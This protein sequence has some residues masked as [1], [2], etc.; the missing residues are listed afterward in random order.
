MLNRAFFSLQANWIPTLVALGN[1]FV[2]VVLD[3]AVRR[4]SASGASRWRRRS[5]TSRAPRRCS[6]CCR[7]RVGRIDF[8]EVA[9]SSWRIVVAAAVAGGAAFG[10]WKALDVAFGDSVVGQ[11][12]AFGSDHRLGRGLRRACLVLHVRELH[13]LLS[14]R[15]RIRAAERR[16]DQQHIRNFCII[17]H[18]DHGKSTLADR[19]LELHGAVPKREMRAQLL[20]SMDLE[21]ERGITIKAQAVDEYGQW[22]AR[23]RA[24]PDRHAGP[25]RLQLRGVALAARRARARCSL[26]DAGAGR[27]GADGRQRLPRDRAQPRRS[28]RSSTRSTCRTRAPT[29]VCEEIETSIGIDRGRRVLRSRRRRG[30]GVADVLDAIIDARSRRPPATRTRRCAR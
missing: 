10:V 28:C 9:S 29:S 26:V 24:Q 18:I 13:A 8:G 25:R 16:M 30:V 6:S 5:S 11:L 1:L 15:S 17:A 27:R 2:N 23:L 4:R 12:L 21:R 3:L 7:R 19:L 14:L 22:R 20:D